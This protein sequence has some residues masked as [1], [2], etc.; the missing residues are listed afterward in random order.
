MHGGAL[1]ALSM[2]V[3]KRLRPFDSLSSADSL[4][5]VFWDLVIRVLP[6]KAQRKLEWTTNQGEGMGE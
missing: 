2:G 1:W 3:E 4:L 6:S 5:Q